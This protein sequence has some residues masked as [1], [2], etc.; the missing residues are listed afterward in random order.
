[1]VGSKKYFQDKVNPTNTIPPRRSFHHAPDLRLRTLGFSPHRNHSKI[2]STAI[3]IK[4]NTLAYTQ[5]RLQAYLPRF[6]AARVCEYLVAL[7]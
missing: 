7:S 2:K 6:F 4:V 1:M 5:V 3:T